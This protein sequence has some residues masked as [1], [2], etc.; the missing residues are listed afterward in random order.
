MKKTR[1]RYSLIAFSCLFIA[2]CGG[3]SGGSG[4]SPSSSSTNN[5]NSTNN[6]TGAQGPA[7]ADNVFMSYTLPASASAPND[8]D[9]VVTVSKDGVV[10]AYGSGA[11]QALTIAA[12]T[13]P[14]TGNSKTATGG[15][16]LAYGS[17]FEPASLA[18]SA[19]SDGTSYTLTAKGADTQASNATLTP[20]SIVITPTVAALAGQYGLPGALYGI[21]IAGTS[22]TGTFS[23]Y[24]A[25]SGTLSPNNKTIDVTNVTFQTSLSVY[26]PNKI[27][28]PYA[29][30]TFNGTAYLLGPSAAYPKGTFQIILDDSAYG[31]PTTVLISNFPRQ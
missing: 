10:R 11:D 12:G 18:L 21:S 22:L 16:W 14:L 15:G 7:V 5:S 6:N 19:N 17:A 9:A 13:P 27:G 23:L 25:L 4:N 26:N 8:N 2:A 24:C 28:C 3:G 30:K 31:T 29:G 1:L 20:V